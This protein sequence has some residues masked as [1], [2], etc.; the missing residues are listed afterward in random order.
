MRI[1]SAA[2][3]YLAGR[4]DNGLNFTGKQ[5]QQLTI[6][7]LENDLIR[8]RFFPDGTPRLNRTW[9]V[10]GTEGDVPLEGRDRNDL[11]RFS[12][13]HFIAQFERETQGEQSHAVV[14]LLTSQLSLTIHE[15][16]FRLE[17]RDAA[18]QLFAEETRNR[19]YAFNPSGRELYHFMKHDSRDHYYGFGEKSGELDKSGRRLE[20]FNLDALGYSARSDDPLYKHMPFYIT[21]NHETGIAYGL[22][23]DTLSTCAFNLGQER[24]AYYKQYRSFKAD[25]G[26]LDYYLIYG[27]TVADVVQKFSQLTGRMLMPPK[28]SLGYLASTM[29]YT[30]APDA[31]QQLESF[32]DRCREHHIPCDLFHLSSG[33]S[34]DEKTRRHTFNWNTRK[35]PDAHAI[36]Q[37]FHDAGIHLSANIKPYFVES[38]PHFDTI[39][40]MGGFIRE[41]EGEDF[42]ATVFWIG[43]EIETEVGG[44]LDFTHPDAY[45]W[46]KQKAQE[47][48]LDYGIDS[49][50]NDNNEFA[51][52]DDEAQV[53]FFGEGL[54][55]GL[56]RPLLTMLMVRASYEAQVANRPDERPFVLT[57]S[58][59]IGM[60][61]YAQSW[62]GDN[63]TSWETLRYNIPMGLGLSL[64]GFPNTG[65]DVGGFYGEPPSPELLTRWVQNGVMHPRFTIHSS[66]LGGARRATEPWMYPEVMPYIRAAIELRY[67]MIPYL[68]SVFRE[69]S[70]TGHPIIRPMVYHFQ[71]DPHCRTESFDFMLG[72]HLLVASVL[73][74][75]ATTRDVYLPA[76]SGWY[77][78]YT[79][80]YYEGGQTITLHAPLERLPLLVREGGMIPM[81]KAM[82]HIGAEPDDQR[83]VYLYPQQ[84]E[85]SSAFI[86]YEDDGISSAYQHGDYKEIAL[87]LSAGAKAIRLEVNVHGDYNL[88]YDQ[89]A[90][91]LPLTETRP[92][93][94][95]GQQVE[96]EPDGSTVF[97]LSE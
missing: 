27:P 90:F 41:A 42:A 76:Q 85:G 2:P 9:A 79:G 82:Q 52:F 71:D 81:G 23:Y 44:L 12:L 78:F 16:E 10:T 8:V 30:E 3:L 18:G 80:E 37:R 14:N 22:L 6:T 53:R 15:G 97:S 59:I 69:A 47:T 75:G 40:Q 60:Q 93:W 74:P 65:H 61:R 58:A 39:R 92:L 84:I 89:I 31:Q 88:P 51:L 77:D 56:I 91:V 34:T 4:T 24:H 36:V 46:W 13:P 38:N 45:A 87:T 62:S 28:W 67:Q 29:T 11:S 35:F 63:A 20:M 96:V 5:N 50:W 33:Y 57:R 83:R 72:A 73:E 95:N 7:V 94:V 32:I 19:A 48:L 49:T 66:H 86:L 1:I 55:L 43:E 26:D 68:Y 21:L 25:D 17:W 64:T 70:Q 54:R